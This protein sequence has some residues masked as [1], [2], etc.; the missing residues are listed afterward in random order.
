MNLR[1]KKIGIGAG[2]LVLLLLVLVYFF[3]NRMISQQIAQSLE[4]QLPDNINLTY[5]NLYADVLRGT[6]SMSDAELA[7]QD[8]G[9]NV[10]FASINFSNIKLRKLFDGDTIVIGNCRLKEAEVLIDNSKRQ[11]KETKDTLREANKVIW[12]QNFNISDSDFNF[13]D[14][15]GKDLLSFVDSDAFFTNLFVLTAPE[16]DENT[17]TY[18]FVKLQTEDLVHNL[19]SLETLKIARLEA[20]TTN[21]NLYNLSIKPNFS[22]SEY[23]KHIQ[24]ERDVIDL[25]VKNVMV[26]NY[27]YSFDDD[28]PYFK[29]EEINL[30]NPVLSVYRDKRMPDQTPRKPLYSEMLRD[31]DLRLEID[32]ILVKNGDI[33][34]EEQV[35]NASSPGKLTFNGLF[36]AINSVYNNQPGKGQVSINAKAQFMNHAPTEVNWS[37]NILEPVD[38]FTISGTVKSL[39][40]QQLNSFFIQNLNAKASGTI[41]EVN[42][43]YSGNDNAATGSMVM[44]YDDFKFTL[45]DQETNEKKGFQTFLANIFVK[46]DKDKEHKEE[47]NKDVQVVRDQQKSFFNYWWLMLKEGLKQNMLKFGMG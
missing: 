27:S 14:K 19:N 36:A 40:A 7:L 1:T 23:Q 20:D 4:E 34:Y 33:T 37:F 30:E 24:E 2:V 38:H 15:D 18:T 11:T 43:N 21:L 8:Q 35:E 16:E 5:K 45:L 44:D 12:V 28:D 9:I 13:K 42:F 3:G 29:S 25:D 47:A 26:S 41:N 39:Q 17:I 6:F 46:S 10:K 31:L 22:R 32:K